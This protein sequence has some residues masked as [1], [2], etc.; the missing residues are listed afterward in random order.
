MERPSFDSLEA[1]LV[2]GA[3][4][5]LT[6]KLGG[7]IGPFCHGVSSRALR[8]KLF[9]IHFE[10]NVWKVNLQGN[11]ILKTDQVKNGIQLLPTQTSI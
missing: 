3:P 10:D 4:E 7:G 9:W 6:I 1:L 5:T 8:G 2:L 11:V